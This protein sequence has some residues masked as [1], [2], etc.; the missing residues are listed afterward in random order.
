MDKKDTGN[1]INTG[2]SKLSVAPNFDSSQLNDMERL[3]NRWLAFGRSEGHSK[4]TQEHDRES[5]DKFLW[6]WSEYSHFDETV[7][8]P[9][10]ATEDHLREYLAYLRE[11]LA[12][13]WGKPVLPGKEKLAAKTIKTYATC[14]RTFFNWLEDEH[15]IETTP[16]TRRLKVTTKKDPIKS[17]HHK[18]LTREQIDL[19]F[20]KLKEPDKLKKYNGV[21][22]LAIIALLLDSGI[23]RGELLSMRVKDIDMD[24]RRIFVNGK[25]GERTVFF[26]PV[27]YNAIVLY[28]KRWRNQQDQ[29]PTTPFWLC[30]D[31]MPFSFSGLGT[32]IN[33]LGHEVGITLGAHMFRHTF[34]SHMV[35]KVGIFE[36][37]E[38]MGHSNVA[39]TEIYAHGSLDKLQ[40]KYRGN[41]PLS[42][43]NLTINSTVRRRRGRP[44]KETISECEEDD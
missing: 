42:D 43:L 1:K 40:D 21:R 16:F 23:R 35:D 15:I 30:S 18:N 29:A 6:W 31:G 27:A 22:N 25:S 3:V 39:T 34:A 44:K 7:G 19:I 38:M 37:K 24:S 41:S 20:S 10:N 2:T 36:L 13:R 33:L 26:G 11:E 8:H 4:R 5:I 14:V 17:R 12:F 32:M 28:K 9:R